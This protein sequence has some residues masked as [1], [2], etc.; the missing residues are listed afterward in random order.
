MVLFGVEV[1]NGKRVIDWLNSVVDMKTWGSAKIECYR[2]AYDSD[3]KIQDLWRK[4]VKSIDNFKHY[5][6]D[7]MF[8]NKYHLVKCSVLIVLVRKGTKIVNC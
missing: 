8:K 4:F 7:D 5:C 3:V 1:F 6:V 2:R